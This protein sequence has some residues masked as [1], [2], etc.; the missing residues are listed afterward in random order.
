MLIDLLILS[1]YVFF[2][3]ND[4][5]AYFQIFKFFYFSFP[6]KPSYH[7]VRFMI[8]IEVLV[9]VLLNFVLK[10]KFPFSVE[11]KRNFSNFHDEKLKM[12][13]CLIMIMLAF[14]F[15]FFLFFQISK[16]ANFTNL[17]I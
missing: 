8:Q 2:S 3:K 5:V 14:C 9:S 15:W 6:Q 12:Q 13:F 4:V 10:K 11:V 7:F 16:I 1:T 17:K